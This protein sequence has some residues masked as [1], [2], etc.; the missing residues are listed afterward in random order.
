MSE[1]THDKCRYFRLTEGS[2]CSGIFALALENTRQLPVKTDDVTHETIHPSVLERGDHTSPQLG[3]CIQNNPSLLCSLLPLE[4]EMKKSWPYV[5][6]KNIPTDSRD[7]IQVESTSVEA[8]FLW[9]TT[10]D[11]LSVGTHLGT[12]IIKEV[13]TRVAA[14]KSTNCVA[15]QQSSSASWLMNLAH[16]SHAGAVL[17]EIAKNYGH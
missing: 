7:S 17:M 5:P 1:S 6:G 3:E 9:S 2:S 10:K 11:M 13:R 8:T 12:E 4:E 14:S 16:E 15:G